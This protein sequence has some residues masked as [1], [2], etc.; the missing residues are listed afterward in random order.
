MKARYMTVANGVTGFRIILFALF[1]FYITRHEPVLAGFLLLAAWGLDGVDGFIARTLHQE[2]EF[3]SYLDKIVDRTVIGFGAIALIS[4][5]Y[6]PAKA[7]LILTKD[8]GL[9]PMVTMGLT[10]ET[11]AEGVGNYGKGMTLLQ[12]V[13]ILWL[14]VGL[15]YENLVIG[16]IATLGGVVA[17]LHLRRLSLCS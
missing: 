14:L 15:P 6:L 12:G 7:L 3:G 13:G 2:T 16:I 9:L 1:L 5:G 11:W 17:F 10:R 4:A 8:I